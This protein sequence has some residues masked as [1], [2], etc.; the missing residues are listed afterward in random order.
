MHRHM[1]PAAHAGRLV[2]SFEIIYGHAFK[3]AILSAVKPETR[4][5]LQ[6]MKQMLQDS[7]SGQGRPC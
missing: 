5:P 4:V 7:R 1:A 3:S 2:L 6:D